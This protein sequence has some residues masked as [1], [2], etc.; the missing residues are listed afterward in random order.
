M[1][2]KITLKSV[3]AYCVIYSL[4]CLSAAAAQENFT[5]VQT[6]TYTIS[7]NKHYVHD[8]PSQND[9]GLVNA[10]VEVP[11]GSTAKWEVDKRSGDLKWEFKKG[12]PRMIKYIGYPGN[13]G[14]IPQTLLS[15]STGGDGDP[16][17]IIV[18]GRALPRG[19]ITGVKI[20]GVLKLFDKGERDDKI[21]AILPDSK[22]RK[23]STIEELDKK[24][25]G[26]SDILSTWFQN[27][28][29]P[30]KI[31][32]EGYGSRTEALN[33][34][35]QAIKEYQ[36]TTKKQPLGNSFIRLYLNHD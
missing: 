10:V 30:G 34:V 36:V 1:L 2:V 15:E 26:V 28:K 27:Y 29:G 8:V 33:L 14:M 5:P 13:Y 16:L 20:I 18:L 24:F 32:V 19:S 7:I 31:E 22:M 12:A 4:L 23:V 11:T 9:K 25:V 17:D 6:D 21:I 3:V 35:S